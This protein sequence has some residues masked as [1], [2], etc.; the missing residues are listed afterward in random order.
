MLS[1]PRRCASGS[2]A[3]AAQVA[4]ANDDQAT[5]VTYGLLNLTHRNSHE[6][7]VPLEPGDLRAGRHIEKVGR[8][9]VRPVGIVGIR[10]HDGG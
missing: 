7:P 9:G 8:A 5:R 3:K 4:D 1:D 6:H 2:R 10:P